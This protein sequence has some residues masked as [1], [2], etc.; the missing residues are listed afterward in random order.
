MP[1]VLWKANKTNEDDHKDQT[2]TKFKVLKTR[3]PAEHSLIKGFTLIEVI[4]YVG[5]VVGMLASTFVVSNNILIAQERNNIN[6]EVFDNAMFIMQ[7]IKWALDDAIIINA[8]AANT[9]STTLSIDK[10]SSTQN[11]YVFDLA[12]NVARLA[13]GGAS[14]VSLVSGHVLVDELT[15]QYVD[16][17]FG[18]SSIRVTLRVS[19]APYTGLTTYN[20][21]TTLQTSIFLT[22]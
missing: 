22:Q 19:N 12:G 13:S 11:S 8:P 6:G 21:S 9:T 10:A 5:I 7:K 1:C 15:F 14:P 20:T 18:P 2:M 3:P 4:L 16:P 17:Q